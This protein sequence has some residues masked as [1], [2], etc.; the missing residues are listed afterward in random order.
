[1]R[2]AVITTPAGT[3]QRGETPLDKRGRLPKPTERASDIQGL[4]TASQKRVGKERVSYRCYV[5]RDMLDIGNPAKGLDCY[6]IAQIF[7]ASSL[8]PPD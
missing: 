3:L 8:H 6:D 1:M 2:S 5:P 7:L 4:A